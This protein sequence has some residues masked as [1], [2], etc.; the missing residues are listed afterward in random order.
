[1]P[2]TTLRLLSFGAE[3][4]QHILTSGKKLFFLL[5]MLLGIQFIHPKL[6][7]TSNIL[8]MFP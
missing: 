2:V 5:I 4:K 7:W 6:V 8:H 3:E 1:M